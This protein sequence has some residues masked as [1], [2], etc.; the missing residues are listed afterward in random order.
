MRR[1]RRSIIHPKFWRTALGSWK[2]YVWH[3][4]QFQEVLNISA[5]IISILSIKKLREGNQ[6]TVKRRT[7]GKS[8]VLVSSTWFSIFWLFNGIDFA[9]RNSN[10]RKI[11]WRTSLK[12]DDLT[13]WQWTETGVSHVWFYFQNSSLAHL[14]Q[15]HSLRQV[16]SSRRE[17][18]N[19][20]KN[21]NIF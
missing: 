4:S 11:Y 15:L 14:G 6:R 17:M 21:L 5:I 7:H 18:S 12:W 19:F 16:S 8:C 10:L 2:G 9:L 13:I 3:V 20:N 1:Y